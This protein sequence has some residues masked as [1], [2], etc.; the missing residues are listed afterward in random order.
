MFAM[1]TYTSIHHSMFLWYMFFICI[2]SYYSKASICCDFHYN[3][4]VLRWRKNCWNTIFIWKK[5][6]Y[7]VY[8]K[9]SKWKTF[10]FIV[11]FLYF[12]RRISVLKYIESKWRSKRFFIS[13]WNRLMGNWRKKIPLMLKISSR[14]YLVA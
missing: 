9:S 14:A 2:F 7:I 4:L 6:M 5:S 13:S 1:R 3:T 11:Y 12:I 8:Q 10:M